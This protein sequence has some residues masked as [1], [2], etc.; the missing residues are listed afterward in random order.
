LKKKAETCKNPAKFYWK[1][2]IIP[3]PITHS[4]LREK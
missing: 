3:S 2:G 1:K 4:N